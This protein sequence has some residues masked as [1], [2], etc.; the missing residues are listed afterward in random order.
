VTGLPTALLIRVFVE[1]S[2][3]PRFVERFGAAANTSRTAQAKR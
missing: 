2:L 1:E 3:Y